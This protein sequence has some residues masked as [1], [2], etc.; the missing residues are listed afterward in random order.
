MVEV[1]GRTVPRFHEWRVVRGD[2]GGDLGGADTQGGV[3]GVALSAD[4]GT[5]H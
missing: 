3:G 1:I 2:C 5:Q 4:T